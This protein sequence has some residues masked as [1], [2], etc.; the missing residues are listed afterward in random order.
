MEVASD[1]PLTGLCFFG[2]S[3]MLSYMADAPFD[4]NLYTSQRV[5]HVACD[6]SW[7]THIMICNPNSASTNVTVTFVD[8]FGDADSA[9]NYYL[10]AMGSVRISLTDL[11]VGK[12][13]VNG[14]SVLIT[15]TVG[16]ATFGLY[17]NVKSGGYCYAAVNAQPTNSSDDGT[18]PF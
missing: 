18:H 8:G 4:D 7:S 13:T 6:Y 16:V 15:S 17:S 10:D 14:G 12:T 5:P 1:Q 3:A 2:T 11:L 9:R